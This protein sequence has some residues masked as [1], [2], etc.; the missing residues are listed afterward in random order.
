MSVD[1]YK[2]PSVSNSAAPRET[3][4]EATVVLA[5]KCLEVCFS[6]R[7]RFRDIQFPIVGER[8]ISSLFTCSTSFSVMELIVFHRVEPQYF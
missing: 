4:P 6:H 5:C 3:V 7:L 1:A 8:V 2:T